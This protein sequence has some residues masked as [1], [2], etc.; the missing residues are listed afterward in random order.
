MIWVLVVE[1][2][3][4]ARDELDG[5]DVVEEGVAA[6]EE[7]GTV[8]VADS[9]LP[10]TECLY[11]GSVLNLQVFG[12]WHRRLAVEQG[13]FGCFPPYWMSLLKLVLDQ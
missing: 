9:G 12:G 13:V 7:P 10:G 5:G 8:V 3:F 1:K 4:E 6:E 2:A 11:L